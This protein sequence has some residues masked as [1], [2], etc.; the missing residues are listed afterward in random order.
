MFTT[1]ETLSESHVQ[2][3]NSTKV[4]PI[5]TACEVCIFPLAVE[6][7]LHNDSKNTSEKVR[8]RKFV[9]IFQVFK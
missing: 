2:N 1:V 6:Q 5:F 4:N 9:Q 8:Y 7:L 3:K